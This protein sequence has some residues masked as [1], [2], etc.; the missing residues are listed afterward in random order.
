VLIGAK[1]RRPA[2]ASMHHVVPRTGTVDTGFPGHRATLSSRDV[3]V[4][5]GVLTPHPLIPT[6]WL[7]W[8]SAGYAPLCHGY[9]RQGQAGGQATRSTEAQPALPRIQVS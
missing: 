5:C 8:A 9:P 6:D 3:C 1:D 7:F 4:K 2:G